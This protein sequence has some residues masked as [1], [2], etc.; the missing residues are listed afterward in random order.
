MLRAIAII[1]AAIAVMVAGV[2]PVAASND[3]HRIPYPAAPFDLPADLCG[4][5]IH[6]DVPFDHAAITETILPDG[7]II[8][9]VSGG[10]FVTATN[11]ANLRSITV[12]GS[13]PGVFTIK[14]YGTITGEF[15]GRGILWATNLTDF[16]FPS[17]VVAAAGPLTVVQ[18]FGSLDFES[19]TGSPQVITDICAALR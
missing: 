5:P 7:T 11:T 12:N 14:P 1:V 2:A 16:G 13:G 17:D 10:M 15:R 3:P 9:K 4:F 6:V 18:A 8:D 19:V